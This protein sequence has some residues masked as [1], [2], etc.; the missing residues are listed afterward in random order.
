MCSTRSAG[1]GW[2]AGAGW[3]RGS[4]SS[5]TRRRRRTAPVGR[6][7][8]RP[9]ARARRVV[10]WHRVHLSVAEVE[11]L[12]LEERHRPRA[13][14]IEDRDLIAALVD[15]AIAVE[16]LGDGQRWADGAPPRDEPRRGT[17]TESRVGGRP[18]RRGELQDLQ[19]FA[20]GDVGERAGVRRCD[21]DVVDV[22]EA[23]AVDLI[24]ARLLGAV[25]VHDDQSLWTGGNIGVAA[26]DV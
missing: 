5:R 17:R 3:R 26:R 24:D 9:E 8:A 25:D 4:R 18:L 7:A 6:R 22:F 14:A 12:H 19:P 21:L 20:V 10:S 13:D 16:T 11:T 2:P 23:F 1:R 15:R